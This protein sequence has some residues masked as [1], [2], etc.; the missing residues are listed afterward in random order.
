MAKLMM[1]CGENK[2]IVFFCLF[3]FC[4]HCFF[5]CTHFF[6]CTQKKQKKQTY[7][8]FILFFFVYTNIRVS[9][10]PLCKKALSMACVGFS[11]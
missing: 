8:C 6:L 10:F 5:V 9:N 1:G 7:I 3:F 2:Q 4:V 11:I